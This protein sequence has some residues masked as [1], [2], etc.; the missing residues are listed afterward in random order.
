MSSFAIAVNTTRTSRIRDAKLVGMEEEGIGVRDIKL[1][2]FSH[3]A[4][5]LA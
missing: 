2:F 5:P 3:K 1:F 4:S